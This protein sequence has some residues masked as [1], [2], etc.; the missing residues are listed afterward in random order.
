MLGAK[1]MPGNRR[2]L[3]PPRWCLVTVEYLF[4]TSG[5]KNLLL[6]ANLAITVDI[7]GPS[8]AIFSQY[9]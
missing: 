4:V 9:R 1:L 3:A 7:F 6:T 8:K 5:L 2:V